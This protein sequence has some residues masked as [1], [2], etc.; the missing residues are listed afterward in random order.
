MVDRK[1]LDLP[2]TPVKICVYG[3][4]HLGTVTAACLADMGL[5][6]IGL[7]EDD[8]VITNLIHSK[9]PLYE[10]GLNELLRSGLEC[11]RLSFTTSLPAGLSDADVVWVTFDT[12]INEFGNAD[13][14]YVTSRITSIFRYLKN[15]T[16]IIISSQ[17]PVGSIKQIEQ[18]F[19]KSSINRRVSFYCLPENVRLG[20]AIETFRN[21]HRIV[22]GTR[23][24]EIPLTLQTLLSSFGSELISV[25]IESAEMTKHA[26][27]AFLGMS[28]AYINEIAEICEHVGADVTEVEQA[29]RTDPRIGNKAYIRPGNAFS[30]G[31]LGRDITYLNH[32]ANQKDLK[33]P[34][35]AGVIA[36][37]NNRRS[38]LFRRCMKILGRSA[39][40]STVA[41]LG[42]AYKP[43]TNSIRRS[44]SIELIRELIEQVA[45]V[46]AF[47]PK[48]KSLPQG[49]SDVTLVTAME[50]VLDG[51][52]VLIIATD[53]SEFLNLTPQLLIKRMAKPVVIDQNGTLLSKMSSDPQIEYI[54]LGKS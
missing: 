3:L 25:Q 35:L 52:H 20:Q 54:A 22:I 5:D 51:A 24:N 23:N 39:K 1:S 43:E 14:D 30:G 13:I 8:K 50:D 44:I 18:H 9:A 15:D 26:L 32:I 40:T 11:N 16:I 53:W 34:V 49:L 27:N 7:D 19:Y 41:I 38:W 37:N 36:S 28:I 6:V 47:D 45:H 48:V 10:P 21:P 46:R 33:T 42:L 31:T 4:W 29:L 2:K 17:L 12:P